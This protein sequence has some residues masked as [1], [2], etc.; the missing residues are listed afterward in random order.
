MSIDPGTQGYVPTWTLGWRM[1]RAM[2]HAGMNAGDVADAMGVNRT[3]ISRWIND[4][5]TPKR[6]F[7]WQFALL[8]R[9][10]REW[11][12]TGNAPQPDGPEGVDGDDGCTRRDSNSQP[13]DP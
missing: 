12:E 9:T 2:A 13:S 4:T 7:I 11:L 5:T 1:Q 8:T 10:N 3:T 6:A